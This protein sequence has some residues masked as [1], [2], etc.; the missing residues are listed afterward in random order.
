MAERGTGKAGNGK[1][2]QEFASRKDMNV[3]NKLFITRVFTSPHC[4]KLIALSSLH[5]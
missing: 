1:R 5:C 3:A 4:N 2:E